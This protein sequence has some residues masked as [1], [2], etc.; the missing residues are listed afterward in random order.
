[1]SPE[2]RTPATS[3]GSGGALRVER[4][5]FAGTGLF[6]VPWTV[7]Y[8][9]S[10]DDR[11]GS[12]LLAGCAGALLALAIYLT[13]AARDVPARPEDSDDGPTPEL[14]AHHPPAISIWPLVIGFAATVVGFGIAFTVWIAVPA[15]LLLALGVL[16]YARES[17]ALA[18]SSSSHS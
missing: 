12:L 16:G 10:S 2:I 17:T 3:A 15:G 13:L 4:W 11:A 7:I 18:S 14:E 6:L 5:I 9:V 8:A 1:M